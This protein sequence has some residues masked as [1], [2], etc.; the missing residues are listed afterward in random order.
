MKPTLVYV[1]KKDECFESIQ[2]FF[3]V[4]GFDLHMFKNPMD[5]VQELPKDEVLVASIPHAYFVVGTLFDMLGPTGDKLV[6]ALK[7]RGVTEDRIMRI[8]MLEENCPPCIFFNVIKPWEDTWQLIFEE[9][10]RRMA[11][12]A[13]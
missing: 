2:R 13:A 9:V 7:R 3:S 8:S 10:Q 11:E 4:K 1:H 5:F 12:K 6:A